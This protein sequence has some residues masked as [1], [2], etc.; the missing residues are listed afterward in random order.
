MPNRS[1]GTCVT[2][3]PKKSLICDSPIS[4]AMPLVKPITTATGMNRT[5]TPRRNI[6]S[7]NNITPDIAVAMIR[8]ATP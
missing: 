6:P 5:S 1:A 8:L 4:T 3:S 7:K 2:C